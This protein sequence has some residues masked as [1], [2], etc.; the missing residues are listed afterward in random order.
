MQNSVLK[1]T[2]AVAIG[3]F[4]LVFIMGFFSKSLINLF[5]PKVRIVYAVQAP[6]ERT[7]DIEGTIQA[8]KTQKIRLNEDVIVAE[9]YVKAGDTV[10]AG[11][12]V[13]R[14]NT[15]YNAG[16][17]P[18]D[19]KTLQLELKGEQLRLDNLS[20]E[21]FEEDQKNIAMLEA[22][23][24][25]SKDE[26]SKRNELYNAG[27]AAKYELDELNDSIM[28]QEFELEKCRAQLEAKKKDQQVAIIDAQVNIE[29]LQRELE[30][31]SKGQEF[32][33]RVDENGVYHSTVD[34]VVLSINTPESILDKDSTVAEIA[35]LAGAGSYMFVTYVSDEDSEMVSEQGEMEVLADDGKAFDTVKIS[36]ISKVIDN[37]TIRIEGEYAPDTKSDLKLGQTRKGQIKKTY[38]D[39]GYT[40][41]KASVIAPDG[42]EAGK[43]GTVYLLEEKDGILGKEYFAEALDVKI[44]AAGNDQVIVS[45]FPEDRQSSVIVNLSYK[46]DNNTR[47][48]LWQ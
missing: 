2:Q 25:R 7:L 39:N 12:A 6:V 26:L 3:F 36:N 38:T 42:F 47:V 4:A 18:G 40:V 34:G 27:A 37:Q 22:E 44:L 23:L 28:K 1:K 29:K 10:K 41:P 5:L 24:E 13:F 9:Y 20:K 45:G 30:D 17:G 46:I 15:G 21:A 43:S 19:I 33:A 14:I 31:A 16:N 8:K 35:E 11:D 48:F 32:Y